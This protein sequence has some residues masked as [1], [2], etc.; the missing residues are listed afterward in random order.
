MPAFVVVAFVAAFTVF[1]VFSPG[2]RPVPSGAAA[3][4]M[5]TQIENLAATAG[6]QVHTSGCSMGGNR[7]LSV[8][9]DVSGLSIDT[10]RTLLISN[11]WR[12]AETPPLTDSKTH[13]AFENQDHYLTVDARPNGAVFSVSLVPLR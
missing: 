9:C 10:L 3:T 4:F 5:Q 6:G 7:R 8:S 12:A 13:L 2:D 11:G 1:F